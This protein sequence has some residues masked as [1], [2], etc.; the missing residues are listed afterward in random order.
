MNSRSQRAKMIGFGALGLALA[1]VNPACGSSK[2]G[3]PGASSGGSSNNTS[4]TGGT[5]GTGGSVQTEDGGVVSDVSC[6]KDEDCV[7]L[8]MVCDPLIALCVK[9][10]GPGCENPDSGT[11]CLTSGGD[12]CSQIPPFVGTQ[13]VDGEGREF[14]GVAPLELD[15]DSAAKVITYN[16]EPPEVAIARVASSSA[17]LHAYVEVVDG[18]V[19]VVDTV[20]SSQSLNQA[21]QGDSI[22]LT[23]SSSNDVTGL[24]GDD[25]NTL[26]VIIPAKGPAVS[27]RASNSNGSSQGTATALPA[28]Q[29]AQRM[30][31][32]GYA[33]EAQLPWPGGNPPAPGSKIRFDLMLNS[34]DATFGNVGDMRDGQLIY[35]LEEVANT[36]CQGTPSAEGTV[37][38]C[39]DR[40]WC[41]T[42]L[43]G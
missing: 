7:S 16:A 26:H 11:S 4:D 10:V 28:A 2:K 27:T 24:T 3:S 13:T 33:I 36:S 5:Q 25:M 6:A 38:F 19:Q 17:G 15:A 42:T 43:G 35:H 14:C 8:N 1:C 21:Y 20:D 29:Y 41:A 31:S 39:D 18:S 12:P 40:T 32:T 23:F 22:E 30:T 37:P 34:A 9:C